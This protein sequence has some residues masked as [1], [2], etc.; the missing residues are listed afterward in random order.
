[1]YKR[2]YFNEIANRLNEPRKFIQVLTGP[3]QSGKTTL[4]QQV[5]KEIKIPS[6]YA[7]TDIVD[8]NSSIWIE[9]QWQIARL[10]LKKLPLKKDFLLVLDEIQ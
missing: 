3:R 8:A 5:M 4:I 10:K 6:H 7:E 2:K 9:Q 1:M